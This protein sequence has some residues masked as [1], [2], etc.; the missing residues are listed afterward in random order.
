MMHIYIYI[1]VVLEER[2]AWLFLV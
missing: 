1:V 2:S